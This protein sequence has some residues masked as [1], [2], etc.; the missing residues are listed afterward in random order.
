[1]RN[2]FERVIAAQSDRLA[3]LETPPT[4]E[5]LSEITREDLAAVDN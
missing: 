3:A 5:Q 2:L 4:R 1:M